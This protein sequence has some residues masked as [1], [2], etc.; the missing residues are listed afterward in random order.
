VSRRGAALVL[1]AALAA[2]AAAR[3]DPLDPH[4][5]L[6]RSDQAVA[7]ASVLRLGRPRVGLERRGRRAKVAEHPALPGAA[8]QL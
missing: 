5:R 8:E 7:A 4:V 3:A 6:T 2:A 1:A